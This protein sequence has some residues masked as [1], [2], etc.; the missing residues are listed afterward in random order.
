MTTPSPS[1][2]GAPRP[3]FENEAKLP[4]SFRKQL[5][6]LPSMMG[7][8]IAITGCTTGT[9]FC[10]AQV[11]A[12]QGA[13]VL[14][15]N[16]PSARAE[17]ALNLMKE[18]GAS[19][20]HVDC[21]LTSFASV[22][23][24]VPLVLAQLDDGALDVLTC[25]AGVMHQPDVVTEDGFDIQMQVN[26]LSHFVLT[27]ELWPA[28]TKA[29]ELRGEARLV[30]HSSAARYFGGT[31][32]MNT[33]PTSLAMPLKEKYFTKHAS[34]DL[35][36]SCCKCKMLFFCGK[37]QDR[38]QQSKLANFIFTFALRD[39]INAAGSK[40]KAV[41]AHPG[42]CKSQ[43]AASG[44][45]GNKYLPSFLLPMM[46]VMLMQSTENGTLGIVRGS[47]ADDTD[48][49]DFFGP[50]RPGYPYVFWGFAHKRKPEKFFAEDKKQK[51]NVWTWCENA[52]GCSFKLT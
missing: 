28:L 39:K 15:L 16:R 13:K 14:M 38:Y 4:S 17:K 10:L 33:I 30:M 7:K 43:L 45:I 46:T 51:E 6:K 49:G 36:D 19:V 31:L 3:V 18:T 27:C 41:V 44:P 47:C 22:R 37:V 8:V 52:T 9:G 40:V 2:K 1:G 32:G 34:G 24:A 20:A 29:G 21:D 5:A 50:S 26:Q 25:N 23:A 42:I 48:N 12:R 35:G 11:A